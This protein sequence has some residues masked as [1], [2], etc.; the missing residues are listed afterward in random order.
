MS[1]MS[2]CIIENTTDDMWGVVEKFT[3]RQQ[4]IQSSEY[5]LR[6]LDSLYNACRKFCDEYEKYLEDKE[7]YVESHSSD[8]ED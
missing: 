8:E 6:H 4:D 3:E 5:E 1:S 2:Y 7:E